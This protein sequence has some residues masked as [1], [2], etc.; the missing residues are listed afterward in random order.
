MNLVNS[1]GQNKEGRNLRDV[2]TYHFDLSKMKCFISEM[3]NHFILTFIKW[4][5]DFL[6][7]N[8]I[9]FLKIDLHCLNGM[10]QLKYF[11]N[12]LSWTKIAILQKDWNES[13]FSCN[14]FPHL[15]SSIIGAGS[16]LLC[17]FI[18]KFSFIPLFYT[19][20]K[21]YMPC[22]IIISF[23]IFLKVFFS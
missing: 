4:N 15:F 23:D 6:I 12:T 19:K 3:P 10:K 2:K 5:T 11:P 9:F 16:V 17:V 21:K 20:Q 8:G 22:Y 1:S 14:Y 18:P 13:H 7:Q